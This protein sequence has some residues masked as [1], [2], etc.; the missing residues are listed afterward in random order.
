[1]TGD[2]E[3][4]R[5]QCEYERRA[6]EMPVDFYDL[7]KPANY[8]EHCDIAGRVTSLLG[9]HGIFPPRGRKIADIGCGT[10]NWLLKFV[11]WGAN[12]EDLFGIDLSSARVEQARQ[13]LPLAQLNTGNAATLPLEDRSVDLA[14]Q[15]LA[16][17]SVLDGSMKQSMATEM[18]RVVRE[19]GAILW[20]DLRIG[21]PVN[22]AVKGIGLSELRRLFPGCRLDVER[23]TLAPPIARAVVPHSQKLATMLR[24]IPA[25]RTHYLALIGKAA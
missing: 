21:N 15:F 18:L 12:P 25:L 13:Q 23:V 10:G 9:R 3:A 1:M 24:K 17:S 22:S 14:C 7:D 19:G 6:R 4:A 8:F 11:E 20:Y 16:F 2:S 5:I